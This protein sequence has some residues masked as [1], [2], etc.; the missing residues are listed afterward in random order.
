MK[1]PLFFALLSYAAL[2][3]INAF[4]QEPAKPAPGE[5]VRKPGE[6]APPP[7]SDVDRPR[8]ERG[9]HPDFPDRSRRP[10]R[11]PD[12]D[13][14]PGGPDNRN[15]GPRY[16]PQMKPRAYIGLLTREVSPEVAAQAGLKPGF[17]LMIAE[18]MKDS[19]SEKAGIQQHDVLVLFGDQKI[20][21]TEQLSALVQGE[22]K[23]A[24]VV[25]TIRRGGADQK[26]TV[27]IGERMMPA[28]SGPRGPGVRFFPFDES[29][30]HY[31]GPEQRERMERFGKEMQE[32]GREF[33]D[34]MKDYQ[35]RLQD[36]FRGPKDGPQ[37]QPPRFEEG[38]AREGEKREVH[39]DEHHEKAITR[40]DD[41]G[42]YRL[43]EEDGRKV[44]TAKLKGEEQEQ[45]FEV[46][47]DEDRAKLPP[48]LLQ[49][50]EEMERMSHQVPPGAGRGP[51]E[52]R[53]PGDRQSI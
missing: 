10:E 38:R 7:P 32:R 1:K 39:H 8:P 48:P 47:K 12:G 9:D 27:K 18:V 36:W 49:K 34:R 11:G 5:E 42:E 20:V 17:G 33:Q 31:F 28:D 30:R 40:R 43:K 6:D 35:E 23:D 15:R 3:S 16:E 52:A 37:P 45:R 21:N 46:N 14:G 13:R 29:S 26:I 19:P 24:E 44:F 53:P 50:L 51:E 2:T 41:T 25:L 22:G 4:A